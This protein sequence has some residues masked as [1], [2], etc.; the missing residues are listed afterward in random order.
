MTKVK[1]NPCREC[2]SEDISVGDCGYSSFN[3]GWALC[4]NCGYEVRVSPCGCFPEEEIIQQW[5]RKNTGKS[6]VADS[7]RKIANQ[8]RKLADSI[9]DELEK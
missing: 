7:I 6:K 3:V 1:I 2:G 8:L 4:K 5:N 9:A